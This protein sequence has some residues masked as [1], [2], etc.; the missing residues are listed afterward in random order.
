M[1][2]RW[3]RD[4]TPVTVKVAE[5]LSD[6]TMIIQNES[7]S[8]AHRHEKVESLI[9]HSNQEYYISGKLCVKKDGSVYVKNPG[10]LPDVACKHKGRQGVALQHILELQSKY[11]STVNLKYSPKSTVKPLAISFDKLV[12]DQ[13]NATIKIWVKIL[14]AATAQSTECVRVPPPCKY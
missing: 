2:G 10:D 5:P 8:E 14:T 7:Y 12:K 3:I 6:K 13:D 9:V 11:K 4:A 1:A